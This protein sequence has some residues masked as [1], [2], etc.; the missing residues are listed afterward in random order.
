MP[1]IATLPLDPEDAT[2]AMS[3]G[4]VAAP[5]PEAGFRHE[6]ALYAGDDEF[7][8]LALAFVADAAAAGRPAL[9]L[10]PADKNRRLRARLPEVPD[11]IAFVDAEDVGANPACLTP[12]WAEFATHRNGAASGAG[13]RGLT[14]PVGDGTSPDQLVECQYHEALLNIAVPDPS[15]WL[16]C[17]YDT[18][19]LDTGLIRDARRSHPLVHP[20]G[21]ARS[22]A[23][24]AG[25]DHYRELGGNSLP[26]AP[27]D[28]P[29]FG[30]GPG[31]LRGLRARVAAAARA[32]G[33]SPERQS[34]LV[35]A[36][37]EIAT[38][39]IRHAGGHGALQLWSDDEWLVCAICDR[40]VI[41]DPLA[42]RRRPTVDDRAGRGLWLA[43]H[44]CDLV[45]VRSGSRGTQ[46][47]LRVARPR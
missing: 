13:A 44:L 38:N 17:L 47:H 16:R 29:S 32:A 34:D 1:G 33:L 35:A 37:N 21:S 19:R 11:G 39:S 4:T 31:E 10:L 45:Q 23:T 46:V 25:A 36:A 7:F 27:P 12:L 3:E 5:V 9:V 6:L 14:E 18:A 15:F 41:G 42:G 26:P 40:G 20:D 2:A 30:F 22:D 8:V 43:N 28:T 24:F